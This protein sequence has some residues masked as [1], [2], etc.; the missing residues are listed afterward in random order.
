[1]LRARGG[2][3]PALSAIGL[4]RSGV[5][6]AWSAFTRGRWA[7]RALL[8]RWQAQVVQEAQWQAHEYG[9]YR[10]VACDLTAFFR[11]TLRNCKT[12]HYSSIY[13]RAFS[14]IP[15]GLL[16][17]I[18][19]V[20]GKRMPLPL[21]IERAATTQKEETELMQQT[22]HKAAVLLHSKE[23]LVSN[24][25][26]NVQLLQECGVERYVT[27][28]AKNFVAYRATC[29]YNGRR[30]K[31]VRGEIVRP[32][33]RT[34]MGKTLAA[35]LPDATECWQEGEQMVVASIWRD[36]TP[37][38]PLPNA[39]HFQVVSISDP[40]FR[41]PLLL[42]STLP[43]SPRQLRDFYVDRWPIEM[44]PQTAKQMLGAARQFVFADEARAPTPA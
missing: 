28:G 29:V 1:L 18:G 38:H 17:R 35:T 39:P 20:G 15:F 23:A 2:L 4:D 11:P 36:L 26:F 6:Q 37:K 44:V 33:A 32:L 8:E 34:Y 24:R 40:R 16:V 31:P 5:L 7:C 25:G 21:H 3:L 9:G 12:A 42:V 22:L 30:R 14:A 10:P 43:L 27:R 41:E 19:S 13:K